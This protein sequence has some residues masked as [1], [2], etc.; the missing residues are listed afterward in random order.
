MSEVQEFNIALGD[1]DPVVVSGRTEAVAHAKE[2]SNAN[3]NMN[4]SLE[5]AD[6]MISMQF[7]DGVLEVF[8]TETR[9]KGKARPRRER[10]EENQTQTAS[11]SNEDEAAPAISEAEVPASNVERDAQVVAD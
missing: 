3:S 7:R 8:V 11:A 2:L 10:T 6:G 1:R 4:V 9:E 5:S